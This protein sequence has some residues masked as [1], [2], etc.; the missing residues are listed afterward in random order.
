MI[1]NVDTRDTVVMTNKLERL[2]RSAFP[3][4]V[5]GALNKAAFNA[6]Q[7]TLLDVTNK[8]FTNRSKNFFKANSRVKMAQGLDVRNMVS[9][10]GMVEGK[11]RGDTNYAVKDLAQQEVGGSIGGRSFIPISKGARVSGSYSKNVKSSSRI[12]NR[13][14]SIVDSNKTQGKT[15]AQKYVFAAYKAGRGGFVIGNRGNGVS[16][17]VFE[18]RGLK[19]VKGF[20]RIKSIPVYSY[21][22]N[23]KVKVGATHFMQRSGELSG[24]QMAKFYNEE[25]QRQINRLMNS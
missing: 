1:L 15:K 21:K 14:G 12:G 13:L 24:R 20:T 22:K 3:L 4:A 23:R 7:K 25:G 16:R 10:V 2:H 18:I 5:R 17:I 11:L 6:K 19:K 8:T 9:E